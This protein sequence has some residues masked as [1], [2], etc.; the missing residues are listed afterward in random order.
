MPKFVIERQYLVPMYQRIV[1]E[2]A[3]LEMACEMA[4]SGDID[5]T[6]RRWIATALR[7]RPSPTPRWF[8]RSMRRIRPI[9]SSSP[10][11]TLT[12]SPWTCSASPPSSTRIRRKPALSS[13]SPRNLLTTNNSATPPRQK[14]RG[15]AASEPS[16]HRDRAEKH[17]REQTCV[18]RR[19]LR[20]SLVGR[21]GLAFG[22]SL[23]PAPAPTSTA[24]HP[25]TQTRVGVEASGE[26][27]PAPPDLKEL[28]N[29]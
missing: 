17:Q 13:R 18:P 25:C 8:P 2:A 15:I 20:R 6:P 28:N 19:G 4:V 5:W 7:Q 27:T 29:T 26:G 24:S 21:E 16:G 11:E 1:V 14:L 3:N 22:A 12:A 9:A 10:A 23:I